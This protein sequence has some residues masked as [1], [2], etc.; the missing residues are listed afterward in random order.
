MAA[1]RSNFADLLEPG[2]REIFDDRYSEIPEVFPQLFHVE[3]SD[4]QDEKDSAVSGFGYFNTTG[5][6]ESVN[7][8]DPVQ[9]YDITYT[10]AKYTKGFK[11]SE[12]MYEDDLYRVMNRKP[13]Q[14]ALAARRTA[15]YMAASVYN[16][17]FSTSYTGGDAKPLAS[18][19]HT[20]ADG[21]SSQSN[22]SSTGI[23]LNEENLNTGMLALESQLDDKGMK[24]G[25]EANT[26]VVPRALKKTASILVDS[27]GR[28][29]T[30]DNDKN[31]YR[32]LGMKVVAWHY[33][34][35]T[36]AWFL[37]DSGVHQ[38]N[39]FWRIKP[40]FKQDNAFDTG[41]GLYKARMR[42]SKGFSDWRGVWGSK[43]DGSAFSS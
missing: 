29:E 42:F 27:D 43:G 33:L 40:E 15:E 2:F 16:N 34:T 20:R 10:H 36:T 14:L 24:I 11:V 39:W 38:V 22:A 19:G 17:A 31:Y 23:V 7:Y 18:V 6:G 12:E 26:I 5:E 4:K 37:V 3:M 32:G 1:Y 13:S 8:E 9:M 35:S 30:T 21:G 25:V 41:M 28:P